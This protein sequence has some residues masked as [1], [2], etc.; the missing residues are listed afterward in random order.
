MQKILASLNPE[1]RAAVTT[2]QGPLLVLAGAGSGKTRVITVRI[3]YLLHGGVDP[4]NVL[5]M[6]FTNKAA[7]EMRERVAGLVGRERAEELTVGTFHAFCVRLLRR[8]AAEAGL[9]R[10]FTICD[11]SDQQAA[12]RGALRELRI[13]EASIQPAALHA[14]I[15]LMKNKGLSAEQ[16]LERARD[17]LDELVGRAWRKYEEHLARSRTVD[18]DDLLTRSVQLLATH[19]SVRESLESHF[20][21]VLV[22]EYQDTNGPQY[23]LVRAIAGRHRNLCVVGDDDQSIYGW[24][25]ADVQKI[26]AFESDFA[27]AKVVRLETNYRSTKAILDAANR[28]IAHNPTRLGKTLK[29]AAGVGEPV[30]TLR[31]EDEVAEADHAA[32]EIAELVRAKRFRWSDFAILFRTATQPR[33]FEVQLRARNVPYVLTGGMS[34]FDRKE[35]RDVLAYLRLAANVRDE[36]SLLRV[37]NAPPRGVGKSTIEKVVAFATE[38]GISA[39]EAFE[40]AREIEGV[41]ESAAHAVATLLEKLARFGAEHPGGNL[42]AWV[43]RLVEAVDYRSE[44]D[45]CYPDPK[46]AEERWASVVEVFDMAENHARRT[47][48]PTLASFLEAL[49][50]SAEEDRADEQKEKR[51]A[52][53]LMTIHAAKG[54]EFPRVYLVGVEEGLLPHQRAVVE[55]GVEEERRLMYVAITRAREHLTVSCTKS[56]SKYGTRVESQ[57]SRFFYEM[58]GERPPK[59]WIACDA[60]SSAEKQADREAGRPDPAAAAKKKAAKQRR[61]KGAP[62]RGFRRGV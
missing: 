11:S 8:H 55:D 36:V 28:V 7:R 26:L 33:P 24:R 46:S 32:R 59:G 13:P 9:A 21:H 40:R 14:R 2:A 56:R 52:V 44:V 37:V 62:P 22:D 10:S 20:R 31:M 1:Q 4:A 16:F 49:T 29:A 12:L 38:H 15:S 61:A 18:F 43:R 25:G 60:R 30:A 39:C 5:A 17:D 23:D 47:Q 3:A 35:V 53:A 51:D 54:L 58:L 34:F 41:P 19:P 57:P 50:L 42:V 45:R 27:G 6:T 48:K